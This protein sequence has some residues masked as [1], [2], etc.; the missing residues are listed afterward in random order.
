M[1]QTVNIITKGEEL[2]LQKQFNRIE[3]MLEKDDGL[4][5]EYMN[6]LRAYLKGMEFVM[7]TLGVEYHRTFNPLA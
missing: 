1:K 2:M 6:N 3:K 5:D 7:D 4:S